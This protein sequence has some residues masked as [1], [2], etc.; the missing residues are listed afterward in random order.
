MRRL[1]VSLVLGAFLGLPAA[2][3][4]AGLCKPPPLKKM[5]KEPCIKPKGPDGKR[6]DKCCYVKPPKECKACRK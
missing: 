1:V 2:S 6:L 4:T 5:I 3:A